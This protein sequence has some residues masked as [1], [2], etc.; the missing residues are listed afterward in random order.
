MKVLHTV[1][2]VG[3][4]AGT[5]MLQTV[6]TFEHNDL[7]LAYEDIN[8]MEEADRGKPLDKWST[9]NEYGIFTSCPEVAESYVIIS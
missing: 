6:H 3:E 4:Y 2:A 9:L 1:H 8:Q 7:L 5:T